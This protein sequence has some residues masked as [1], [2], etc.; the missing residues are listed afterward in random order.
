MQKMTPMLFALVATGA[1]ARSAANPLGEVISLM[2]DLAAKVTAEG[3]AEA[4][5]YKEYFEWCDDVAK[6]KQNEITTAEA[7]KEKLQA[8]IEELAAN[9]QA[10]DTK[11]GELAADISTSTA[12]LESATAIRT[13]EAADFAKGEKE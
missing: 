13:K 5:A 8:T 12:D 2:N 9:I 3:E 1:S 6:N 10:A 4:K 7:R 11:I